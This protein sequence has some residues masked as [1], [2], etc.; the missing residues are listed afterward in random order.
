MKLSG[1]SNTLKY[2]FAQNLHRPSYFY[3]DSKN[4]IILFMQHYERERRYL[5]HVDPN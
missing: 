4:A 3:C 5:F 1:I 2:L